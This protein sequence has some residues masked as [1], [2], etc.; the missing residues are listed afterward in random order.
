VAAYFTGATE[1]TDDQ[2]DA[3]IAEATRRALKALGRD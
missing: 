3:V 1:A 2:R